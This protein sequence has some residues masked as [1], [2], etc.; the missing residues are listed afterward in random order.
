VSGFTVCRVFIV[1]NMMNDSRE[2][3]REYAQT[4][5]ET[6]FGEL[7]RRYVNLVYSTALRRVNGDAHL[8]EDVAQMV[9]IDLARMAPKLNREILIGGWLHKHTLHLASH[10]MR[11]RQRRETREREAVA[12]SAL[13]EQP[14]LSHIAPI[15][16]EAIQELPDEDRIAILAR[17][18]ERQ[19]YRSVGL[20][21][22]STEEAARK[23]VDR[24]LEKLESLLK[25]R[26]FTQ[27][28]AALG[29][30]LLADSVS[31]A[32]AGLASTLS[33]A[34]ITAGTATASATGVVS[35]LH[36]LLT[37]K[38][39]LL[40]VAIAVVASA[41]VVAHFVRQ[42]EPP[43]PQTASASSPAT[44]NP[45][46][47]MQALP[48]SG[49]GVDE[50]ADLERQIQELSKKLS[51]MESDLIRTNQD[52]PRFHALHGKIHERVTREYGDALDAHYKYT[53]VP[54]DPQETHRRERLTTTLGGLNHMI[55]LDAASKDKD[56]GDLMRALYAKV[57]HLP[58]FKVEALNHIITN[59]DREMRFDGPR[60]VYT[61]L[62]TYDELLT[63]LAKRKEFAQAKIA[64][65]MKEEDV[66]EIVNN[67]ILYHEMYNSLDGMVQCYEL[68]SI[69]QE[70]TKAR[71]N[72]R[73]LQIR[74]ANL[75]FSQQPGI[76]YGAPIPLT[77]TQ[78]QKLK[79][80]RA[81]KDAI[82]RAIWR[83]I[84]RPPTAPT[85]T[86]PPL[87]KSETAVPTNQM[88]LRAELEALRNEE[89]LLF[90]EALRANA[91][92]RTAVQCYTNAQVFQSRDVSLNAKSKEE[93]E[94]RE[95]I[96]RLFIPI[97][98]H[99]MLADADWKVILVE[100]LRITILNP[101][102]IH[103]S[104]VWGADE[105]LS[106][107]DTAITNM[108]LPQPWPVVI[109]K[110]LDSRIFKAAEQIRKLANA[111]S[112]SE[113]DVR[114]LKMRCQCSIINR[115]AYTYKEWTTPAEVH[116]VREKIRATENR[117]R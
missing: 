41:S 110:E 56:Y 22:G 99:E 20:V 19:D 34:A 53:Y 4:R 21:L 31:A 105:A 40:T 44:S 12:M 3:L 46:P 100:D 112:I 9:F 26:G 63:Q 24:A 108:I 92:L 78:P 66:P 49:M 17:F 8:A 107:P 55:L 73:S 64:T 113:A 60:T 15:I 65:L 5:S 23:R 25:K 33:T 114:A 6:A 28:A 36:A 27:S 76:P 29:A 85:Q 58:E 2:L 68:I 42:P 11:T 48:T 14:N 89:S 18:F 35:W 96:T 80:A 117:L 67:G 51:V 109:E 52:L 37:S 79:E 83:P 74:L 32:P 50:G 54:D 43:P 75:R 77:C 104:I 16:D 87:Q 69:P 101:A 102:A 82:V 72:L 47:E 62:P 111:H 45:Q 61:Q 103:C 93:S 30:A 1:V 106:L 94:A 57:S 115:S 70:L 7:T 97:V 38:I 98:A 10:V 84:N 86:T 116:R 90:E 81:S 13:Q 39:A 91:A 71:E 88:E 95:K 59:M